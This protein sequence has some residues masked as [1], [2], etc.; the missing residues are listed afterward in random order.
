MERLFS[1]CVTVLGFLMVIALVGFVVFTIHQESKV[2]ESGQE[3]IHDIATIYMHELSSYTVVVREG[4]VE[5][6]ISLYLV[7]LTLQEMQDAIR[8]VRDVEKGDSPWL[9]YYYEMKGSSA[10]K[11]IHSITFHLSPEYNIQG[12]GWNHG[13]FGQGQTL[14]LE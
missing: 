1:G 4:E 12:G 7:P 5:R 8:I 13:K 14:I 3:E 11:N 9:E 2:V 6:P 10:V